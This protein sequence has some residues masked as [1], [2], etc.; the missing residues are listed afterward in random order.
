MAYNEDLCYFKFNII[1]I[2][3]RT[4]LLIV[5]FSS[6]MLYSS[7][8]L[9]CIVKAVETTST[10]QRFDYDCMTLMLD[11]VASMDTKMTCF[12]LNVKRAK[13]TRLKPT[14]HRIY[15]CTLYLWFQDI[16]SDLWS[17]PYMCVSSRVR[18]S[19]LF[20]DPKDI[21]IIMYVR[22]RI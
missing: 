1:I 16:V 12:D 5:I 20:E 17:K 4:Y 8:N 13:K 19:L 2:K 7:F 6:E 3:L 14:D 21:K 9:R 10:Q 18:E 11:R 22:I 15:L